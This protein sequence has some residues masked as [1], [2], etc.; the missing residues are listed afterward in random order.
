[1][2]PNPEPRGL[3]ASTQKPQAILVIE[4][5]STLA[6]NLEI[7]KAAVADVHWSFPTIEAWQGAFKTL[8]EA[9]PILATLETGQRYLWWVSGDIA[10]ALM[11]R[12]GRTDG[13]KA[14]IGAVF[15]CKMRAIEY[16]AKAAQ[17]FLP[18]MRY[19]DVPTE[20][21]REALQWGAEQAVDVFEKALSEGQNAPA[22][23]NQR[24]LEAG[25]NAGTAI[26]TSERA[27]LSWTQVEGYTHYTIRIVE[28]GGS[29]FAKREFPVVVTVAQSLEKGPDKPKSRLQPLID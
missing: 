2:P 29:R 6:A 1:M 5:D 9:L 11:R 22:L 26:W 7:I 10:E 16:R 19:P 20:L 28:R 23:R 17:V 24:M 14:R 21:Y 3:L 15:S 8:E 18:E 4:P 27:L 25:H 13:V 12:F